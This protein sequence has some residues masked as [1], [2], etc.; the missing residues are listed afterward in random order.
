MRMRHRAPPLQPRK[1]PTAKRTLEVVE[2]DDDDDGSDDDVEAALGLDPLGAPNFEQKGTKRGSGGTSSGSSG[3][4]M[5]KNKI[6]RAH[7]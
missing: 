7:V 4:D 2:S 1:T 5:R 3:D 6:G